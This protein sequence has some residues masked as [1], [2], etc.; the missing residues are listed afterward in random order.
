MW[1]VDIVKELLTKNGLIWACLVVGVIY[2]TAMYLNKYLFRG[3]L[4]T[5]TIAM[6]IAMI[7]SGLVGG[8][9]W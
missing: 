4:N 5:F 9:Y 1:L 3:K 6:I 2:V 7:I 8:I